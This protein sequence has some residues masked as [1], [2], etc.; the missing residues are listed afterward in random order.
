MPLKRNDGSFSSS[1]DDNL[2]DDPL[3]EGLV[4]WANKVL[5]KQN[6][7]D[8]LLVLLKSNGHPDLPGCAHTLLHTS[9]SISFQKKLGTEYVYFPLA[10][11]QKLFV[12]WILLKSL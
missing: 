6:A 3:G 4:N 11:Q 5:I 12:E 9:R 2:N 8:S 7:L 1:E 10:A